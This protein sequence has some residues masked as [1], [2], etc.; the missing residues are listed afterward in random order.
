[1]KDFLTYIAPQNTLPDQPVDAAGGRPGTYTAAV[2]DLFK[3]GISAASAYALQ[4]NAQQNYAS[5][6]TTNGVITMAGTPSGVS[7]AG[8]PQAGG[9]MSTTTMLMIGG[10]VLVGLILLKKLA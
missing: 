3:T 10:A 8:N 4:N 9:G 6:G 7:V 1:M 5:Y 2:L